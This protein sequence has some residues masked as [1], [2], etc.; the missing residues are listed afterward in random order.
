M[1][2]LPL[3][4]YDEHDVINFCSL[5]EPVANMGS[6]VQWQGSGINVDLLTATPVG[7]LSLQLSNTFNPLWETLSKVKLTTGTVAASQVAGMIVFNV[8]EVDENG[9]KIRYNRTKMIE[10]Q[11]VAS[12]K[13]VPFAYEG[14]FLIGD[15]DNRSGADLVGAKAG[16]AVIAS[17]SG[18]GI[19]GVGA[20]SLT[21]ALGRLG[22]FQ[23]PANRNGY[24]LIKLD[25]G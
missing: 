24:A 14:I 7:N 1:N 10:Q 22:T 4:D 9:D 16:K 23:G 17:T 6:L 2:L 13:N 25:I 12:G 11:T 19:I 3:R 20:E 15:F 21:P 5:Q 8:R 18:G